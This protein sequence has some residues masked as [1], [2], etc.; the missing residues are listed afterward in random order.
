[1]HL[2]NRLPPGSRRRR[3]RRGRCRRWAR[4]R[5]RSSASCPVLARLAGP[6][7]AVSRTRGR[8]ASGDPTARRPGTDRVERASRGLK[9]PTAGRRRRRLSRESPG[10]ARACQAAG[11]GARPARPRRR[12]PASRFGRPRNIHVAPP[13]RCCDPPPKETVGPHHPASSSSRSSA[14]RGRGRSA[15]CVDLSSEEPIAVRQPP[16][17]AAGRPRTGRSAAA[18]AARIF[19]GAAFERGGRARARVRVL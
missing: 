1:M 3:G 17:R 8:R 14:A 13:P 19:R 5:P 9:M 11:R 7:R 18:G 4:W 12:R 15:Y 16:I 10:A 2:D 6:S